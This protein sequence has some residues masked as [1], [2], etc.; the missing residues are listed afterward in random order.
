MNWIV[1]GAALAVVGLALYTRAVLLTRLA[2]GNY[3]FEEL[4]VLTYLYDIIHGHPA[5]T[6]FTNLTFFAGST[7]WQ[8]LFGPSLISTRLLSAVVSLV[9]LGFYYAAV[10]NL[11][12][13]ASARYALVFAVASSVGIHFSLLAIETGWPFFFAAVNLWVGSLWPRLGARRDVGLA[14]GAFIALGSLTYPGYQ[15]WCASL[16]PALIWIR[17]PRRLWRERAVVAAH[18]LGFLLVMGPVFAAHRMF[19]GQAPFGKGGGGVMSGPTDTSFWSSLVVH[20]RDTFLDAASYYLPQS[21]G[22]VESGL[23]GFFVTGLVVLTWRT[24]RRWAVGLASAI[25]VLILLSVSIANFPGMRR[26]LLVLPMF[27]LFAG[28]GAH[29]FARA[30][31]RASRGW[32]AAGALV[33]VL[34][35]ANEAQRL[36]AL[37]AVE[38]AML[39]FGPFSELLIRPEFDQD[40]GRDGVVVVLGAAGEYGTYTRHYL[41]AFADLRRRFSRSA[42]RDFEVLVPENGT[43]AFRLAPDQRRVVYFDRSDTPAVFARS[44]CTEGPI[45]LALGS[46]T[47]YRSVLVPC[48]PLVR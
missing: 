39:P 3:V 8:C 5:L 28:H 7:A 41:L 6:G 31:G 22:F 25:V 12:G 35:M 23:F 34:A 15:L 29:V 13:R 38:A 10:R 1:A 11:L 4:G 27:Y 47:L 14:H 17:G 21:S 44:Y 16:L 20:L 40:L 2:G 33:L 30:I 46:G 26:A 18:A 42:V 19:Q 48:T 32:R 36:V 9:G 37:H 24:R 43:Y 45:P